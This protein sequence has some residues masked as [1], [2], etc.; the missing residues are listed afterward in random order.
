MNEDL[1]CCLLHFFSRSFHV[2]TA[3]YDLRVHSTCRRPIC[4]QKR[5]MDKA[6]YHHA[7]VGGCNTVSATPGYSR[8]R[9][10]KLAI[11]TALITLS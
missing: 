10:E 7:I 1:Y 11:L 6:R 3:Q 4:N 2:L 5:L 8:G 9:D